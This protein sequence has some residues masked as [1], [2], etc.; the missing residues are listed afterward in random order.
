MEFYMRKRLFSVLFISFLVI[1][2]LA[3][4]EE[5]GD[6]FWNKPIT[7]IEFEGLD[8][9]K[10]S[11]LTGVVSSFIEE[12]FTEDV[13]NDLLD[14]LYSLDFFEDVEPYAKHDPKKNDSVLLVFK[15]TEHPVINKIDFYGNQKIRNGELRDLIKTKVSDVFVESK[16]LLDER[17]L[18]EHYIEKGYAEAKVTHKIEETENGVN[19]KFVIEEGAAIVIKQ[20]KLSG[21][22]I[23]SERVLKSKLQL[24]EVSLFKDGGFQNTT[25]EMDKK[26]I[27]AYYQERGYVDATILDVKIDKEMNEEKKRQE[28][29]ITFFIQEGY[30]YTFSGLT[31]EGNSVFSTE[32]L[33]ALMKLKVGTIFNETKFEE[34]IA[35]IT[36]K[37]YENGYMSNEFYR[38]PDKDVERKEIAF[39]LN[40]EEN[41]RSHIENIIIKGNSKTKDFVIRRE[42]PLESGDIFSREKVMN[43]LRNLYSL[44]FFS[45]ILPD[46]QLGSEQN[47]VDL[48]YT[49]EEQS[50]T[51]LNFGMT[52][53]GVENPND[54]PISLY[55]S[56]QNSN[57]FGE[58]KSISASTNIS[59]TD[60]SLDFS[61][62]QNWLWNLPI[63][64]SES[65]SFA[66]TK[67]YTQNNMFSPDL[68]LNQYYYYMGYE[69]WSASI[70]TAFSR[71]WTPDFAILTSS[72][73]MN[74]TFTRYIY[75][76]NIYTPLDLGI[77]VFANRWGN[78]NSVFTSFSVDARDINYEPSKGWFL[79]ERLSWF[80]LIPK[81][82]QEF[83]LKTDTKLE[84]YYTLCDI[85]VT[86]EWNLKFVLAGYS[87]FT[88]LFPTPNSYVSDT[89]KL[90][91]DGLING[92]GWSDG[93]K[94]GRGKA[95]WSNKAEIRMPAIPGILGFN[96]FFDAIT[97]KPSV[98][99]MFTNLSLNDFYFSFG[100]GIR[101][102]IPQLPLHLLF[103]WRY[104]IIDGNVKWGENGDNPFQFILS[105]NIVN[106]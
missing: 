72:A 96:F 19:V 34:G 30:Q 6:W 45:S 28:L 106:R 77:S 97:F 17:T 10:K 1:F 87:G 63:A 104:Q 67:T 70:G 68:D 4:Q 57:L 85:P 43:G 22:T 62:T 33:S 54:L 52:F 50:T 66:H 16:I 86:E 32:E 79:S 74:N 29:T 75:D 44:Q 58:G 102:L 65:I 83:F 23:V 13:Y 80:G 20:I 26:T 71:R 14:R 91:I 89:N 37:Y 15:V 95:L 92:R 48:I 101:F 64:F 59:T 25:L 18:R 7:K 81:W 100:P 39:T 24:K 2:G 98:N 56:L 9:V 105:F 12:P 99:D 5:D 21:N 41:V 35:A 51:S 78:T 8:N 38:I 40:I 55:F 27:I 60:Q 73:G 47:L 90:Y 84:G 93:Y 3:A 82:E 88:G 31:I 53:S 11:D 76:E 46:V 94:L 69:G 42:I 61:Y 103:A 36:G 49:V